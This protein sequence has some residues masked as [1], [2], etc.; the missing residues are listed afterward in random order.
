MLPYC[1]L[2]RRVMVNKVMVST[3]R[4]SGALMMFWAPDAREPSVFMLAVLPTSSRWQTQAANHLP[5]NHLVTGT[6]SLVI[7]QV[8]QE[9][10]LHAPCCSFC[11]FLHVVFFCV[12][13]L[14]VRPDRERGA[15]QHRRARFV[16]VQ[17]PMEWIGCL[18]GCIESRHCRKYYKSTTEEKVWTLLFFTYT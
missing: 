8:L 10:G 14:L 13:N 1:M 2:M 7:G 11:L 6:S 5:A 16:R 4:I 12:G 18:T 15:H 9:V 17:R 3:G